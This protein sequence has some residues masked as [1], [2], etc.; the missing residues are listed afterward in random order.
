MEVACE[1]RHYDIGA[2]VGAA[3]YG[4]CQ[5]DGL[6]G[7]DDGYVGVG[8]GLFV[9]AADM[10]DQCFLTEGGPEGRRHLGDV[11]GAD[12][13]QVSL[14]VIDVAAVEIFH[15]CGQIED[16]G[17]ARAS[18]GG[19]CIVLICNVVVVV[20]VAAYAGDSVPDAFEAA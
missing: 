14:V 15:I 9:P 5:D 19:A 18:H 4:D 11:H 6:F 1:V 8:V 10:E 2:V 13:G 3:L 17:A 12:H 20:D 7:V 16:A